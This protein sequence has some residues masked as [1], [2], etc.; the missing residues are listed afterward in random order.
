MRGGLR[1]LVGTG[2]G[3]D[4]VADHC[5]HRWTAWCVLGGQGHRVLVAVMPQA[6]VADASSGTKVDLG[7]VSRRRVG[8]HVHTSVPG[9]VRRYTPMPYFR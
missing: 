9:I 8:D 5:H 7:M 4:A 1:R 6:P 2:R 3:R